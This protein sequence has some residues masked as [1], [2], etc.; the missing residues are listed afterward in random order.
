MGVYLIVA[1][2]QKMWGRVIT[3]LWCLA[4]PSPGNKK[5]IFEFCTK[6]AFGNHP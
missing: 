1:H 4:A 3:P 5:W 2:L 6:F